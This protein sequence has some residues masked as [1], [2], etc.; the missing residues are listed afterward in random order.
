MP[1][2]KK[3][4]EITLKERFVPRF[5]EDVDGRSAIVK[6]IRR[7]LDELVA[8]A[9]ANSFQKQLL[10]KEAIFIS[11]QLETMRANAID[12]GK[13]DAGVYTQM[14][15]ALSGLLAKLGLEK[16]VSKTIDLKAYV[17]RANR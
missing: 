16:K 10:A 7:R 2:P 4:M 1:R 12:G 8:D 9:D 17:A 13:L 15:N 3:K 11:I 14:V 6:E 5:L